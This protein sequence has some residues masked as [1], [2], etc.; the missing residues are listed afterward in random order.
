MAE[1]LIEDMSSKWKPEAYK[2]TYRTDIMK[3]V[4]AKVRSGK[5]TE[6]SE[7]YV[8]RDKEQ[9][10]EILDLMPLLKKSLERKRRVPATKTRRTSM[11]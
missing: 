2:D 1:K 3:L 10:A 6:I 7:D 8:E 9:T 4:N 11:H 5:A